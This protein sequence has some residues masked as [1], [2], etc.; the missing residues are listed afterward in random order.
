[1]ELDSYED[2]NLKELALQ[3]INIYSTYSENWIFNKDRESRECFIS[4]SV[5]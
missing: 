4:N 1:M 2:K 3:K 5:K